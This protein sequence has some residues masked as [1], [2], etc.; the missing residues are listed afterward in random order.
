MRDVWSLVQE[1]LEPF[2]SPLL[3]HL[4]Q[5]QER[6]VI[7]EAALVAANTD[8][9]RMAMIEAYPQARD[10]ILTVM[11]GFDDDPLPATRHGAQFIVAYAGTIYVDRDPTCLFRAARQVIEELK[12]SP[13]QFALKFIGANDRNVSLPAMAAAEGIAEFVYADGARP[14]AQALE[15]LSHATMLVTLPQNWDMSIPAKIFEYVRFDAWLLAL[16]EQN[17]ATALVLRG[18]DA[19]VVSPRDTGAIAAVLR[20][21][22][23]QYVAGARPRRIATDVRLSRRYQAQVL[24]D[25]IER[26]VGNPSRTEARGSRSESHDSVYRRGQ[27]PRRRDQ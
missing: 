8:V 19:D 16:A 21:R 3:L 27:E 24:L 26:C 5:R 1:C 18:T 10:R 12:L 6:R 11:N 17:S 2:A 9:V 14:R 20:R 4:A 22:Y 15:F 13:A 25:A 7:E 23:E